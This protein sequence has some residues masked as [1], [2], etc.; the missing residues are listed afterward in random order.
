LNQPRS[1]SHSS[2]QRYRRFRAEQAWRN[3]HPDDETETASSHLKR[4]ERRAYL[5]RYREL[6]WPYRFAVGQLVLIGIF[7]AAC[8]MIF[9][10]A[11]G[12]ITDKILIN[13]WQLTHAQQIQ[14]LMMTS[15]SVLLL[16]LLSRGLETYRNIKTMS[17]NHRFI[18]RLRRR[19][20]RHLLHLPLGEL[21]ELKTGSIVSRLSGD[22]DKATGLLQRAVMSPLAA[23]WRVLFA[24]TILLVW[25][26]KLALVVWAVLPPMI[27]VS[28]LWVKRIRPI[29]RSA[30]RDRNQIDARATE[31]FS[32]IRVVR[33]FRRENRE[34]HDYAVADNT[35]VRKRLFGFYNAQF[36]DSVWE[37]L[38]PIAGIGIVWIGGY[39]YLSHTQSNQTTLG[40]IMAFQAYTAQLLVP[41][42]RIVSSL[43]QT[44]EGITAMERVFE[45]FDKPVDKPDA[46]DAVEAPVDVHSIEF[47]HMN[48]AY[49]NDKP[50]IKD[51]TLSVPGGWVVALVGSSGAG[52]TT[53]TDL[54][55]RFYDP[56]DGSIQL[57]GMDIRRFKLASYRRL[58]AVV[59]QETFLFDGSVR[60]NISYGQRGVSEAQVIEAARSA[61]AYDFIMELPDQF[62][63]LI[64]ERGVKLSG[65]QRQRISIA[66]AILADPRILVL[67]EATSN[68][69]TQSEQL[70]QAALDK[71]YATRTT[72]VIAHRLSTVTHADLI[73]VMHEGEIVES[74]RHEE[75][76]LKEGMYYEM[77]GRQRQFAQQ[78]ESF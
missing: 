58:I 60:E 52:K 17:L 23:F 69:D 70:I 68:L 59:P 55:A 6:I 50:V 41:V 4:E 66:R 53:I 34:R 37:V 16:L 67:D 72:F 13:Q 11:A 35:M 12:L 75:L 25:N 64:G 10:A 43:N 33:S 74:G 1:Q 14:W 62:D 32:G 78:G 56:V 22:V 18:V 39:L 73:V 44:Q 45:L 48:F 7:A 65:G 46:A 30:G 19:L 21:H 57:N 9:P 24:S 71:L 42:F 5:Q 3:K 61:N 26:W 36:V 20:H 27:V 8:E 51:F 77:V 47:D 38:I 54:I 63:T 2:R 31:A 40:Q 29:F 76:M 49:N 15:V 28:L